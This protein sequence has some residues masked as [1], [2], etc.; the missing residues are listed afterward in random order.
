MTRLAFP[1]V[2]D[3]ISALARFLKGELSSRAEPPGAPPT[4][5]EL[6]NM[7]ARAA[8]H[9]NF[10]HFRAEAAARMRLSTR[11]AEAPA[12]VD[13]RKVAR[14]TRHFDGAGSLVRWPKRAG[15]RDLCLWVMWSHL[16]ARAVLREREVNALLDARHDFGDY[17]LLRRALCDGGFVFRTVDGR[18]YRRIERRPPGE[19]LALIRHLQP[20]RMGGAVAADREAGVP[21]RGG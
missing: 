4:H 9:R 15:E 16:P 10:Q 20:L 6:L 21:T 1:Y 13:H 14:A 3:D 12:A 19:A 17:A 11:R 2:A 5:V 8:G 7:L 18:A